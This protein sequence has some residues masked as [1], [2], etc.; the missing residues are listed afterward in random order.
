MWDRI[1]KPADPV[2]VAAVVDLARRAGP[3]C[4]AVIVVAVDGHSG[5]GKTTL[6]AAVADALVAQV[7]HLDLVYPGWDGLARAVDILA[8]RILRPLSQGRSAAYRRWDWEH[9]EWA[10]EHPVLPAPFLVVDGCG[11]SVLP[12][13]A[14]AAVRV[15]LDA[16]PALR[17]ARGLA[18]DGDTYA[19]H[20]EHWAAQE[21]ELFERDG[22]RRRADLLIDT[23]TV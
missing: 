23:T 15:F 10:E 5:S 7:V 3:R 11:S 16:S 4:G 20:W 18:R 2:H 17:R 22:T 14:Y 19:P 9:G 6:A 8:T 1:T 12:A 13:G 21:D